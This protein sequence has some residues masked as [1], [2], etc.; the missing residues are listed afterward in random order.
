MAVVYYLDNVAQVCISWHIHAG[1]ETSATHNGEN[2]RRALLH[3]DKGKSGL[4]ASNQPDGPK[5]QI[6]E[7]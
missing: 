1:K 3:Q 5:N 4:A 7:G 6:S 2:I